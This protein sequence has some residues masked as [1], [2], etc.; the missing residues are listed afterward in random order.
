MMCKLQFRRTTRARSTTSS[1][2]T[3]LTATQSLS[4]S[5]DLRSP[6]T[7]FSKSDTTVN[8]L[9]ITF[10]IPTLWCVWSGPHILPLTG[11]AVRPRQRGRG[12]RQLL[13]SSLLEEQNPSVFSILFFPNHTIARQRVRG[14]LVLSLEEFSP[15]E[16][17]N[18]Y[19]SAHSSSSLFLKGFEGHLT[20]RQITVSLHNKDL[21]DCSPS[22][23]IGQS[24][25]IGLFDRHQS[26]EKTSFNID[27]AHE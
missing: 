12:G 24:L 9:W 16:E 6:S 15:L 20:K 23:H 26:N 21:L 11:E 13:F 8:L 17:D 2:S 7:P 22:S 14:L 10:S 1:L 25:I 5:L 27:L 4:L 19:I 3:S 18:S